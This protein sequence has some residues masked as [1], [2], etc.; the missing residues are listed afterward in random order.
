MSKVQYTWDEY[1][2]EW[3]QNDIFDSI[4]ECIENAKM[5]YDIEAGDT[6]FVGEVEPYEIYVYAD[7][8]L[9]ELEELAYEEC[10]EANWEPTRIDQKEIDA[11]SD[12]LTEIVKEWLKEHHCMPNFYTIE[13]IREIQIP[14]D[15]TGEETN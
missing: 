15:E 3:W 13:N 9:E 1:N 4:D 2:S 12:K 8:I 10:E 11:L 5:D 14:G 7:N 6:I